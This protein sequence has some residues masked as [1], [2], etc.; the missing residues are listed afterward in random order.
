MGLVLLATKTSWSSPHRLQSKLLHLSR[1][2]QKSALPAINICAIPFTQL[3]ISHL[4]R[5]S[6]TRQLLR[7]LNVIGLTRLVSACKQDLP[8]LHTEFADMRA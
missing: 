2:W 6:L 5:L 1:S 4:L 3:Q 8:R 7:S